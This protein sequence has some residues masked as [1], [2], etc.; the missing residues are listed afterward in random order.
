MAEHAKILVVDDDPAV[1][2]LLVEELALHYTVEGETSAT[3][4]LA[5][6]VAG[7]YDIVITDVEMPELRGTELLAETRGRRRGR[8]VLL[9]TAFGSIELA[10][11]AVRAGACDFVTK[12]FKLPAL[13][14]A[15]E[16]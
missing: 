4:A 15:V 2:E 13:L 12:P 8:L 10:V 1:V 7:D 11:Q 9:I 14:L 5:R 6:V 3:A 16:R